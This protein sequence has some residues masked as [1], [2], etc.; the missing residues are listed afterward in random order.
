MQH[1]EFLLLVGDGRSAVFVDQRTVVE[2]LDGK[3][4]GQWVHF[5]LGQAGGKHVA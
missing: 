3:R 4:C 5:T 1:R 2:T